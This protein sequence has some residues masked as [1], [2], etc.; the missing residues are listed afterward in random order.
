MFIFKEPF[1]WTTVAGIILV[2]AGVA[3]ITFRAA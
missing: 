3:L 2:I 1:Q